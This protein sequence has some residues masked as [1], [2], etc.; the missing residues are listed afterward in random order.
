MAR[1]AVQSVAKQM[2]GETVP[3]L[4]RLSPTLVTREN[5]YS[6]EVRRMLSMDWKGDGRSGQ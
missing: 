6:P 5:L 2:R 4:I 1:L 3:A